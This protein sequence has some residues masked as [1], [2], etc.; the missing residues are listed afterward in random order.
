MA[1]ADEPLLCESCGDDSIV[2][3]LPQLP[4]QFRKCV[5]KLRQAA[6]GSS[7]IKLDVIRVSSTAMALSL[8]LL[9]VASFTDCARSAAH[10]AKITHEFWRPQWIVGGFL[11]PHPRLKRMLRLRL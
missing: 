3:E 8:A 1:A 7:H 5:T 11:R 4:S 2:F 6:T 10:P 9:R